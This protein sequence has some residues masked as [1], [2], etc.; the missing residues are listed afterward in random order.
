MAVGALVLLAACGTTVEQARPTASLR[1]VSAGPSEL[2]GEWPAPTTSTTTTTIPIPAADD[3]LSISGSMGPD[4]PLEFTAADAAGAQVPLFQ[5]PNVPVPSGRVLTNPT[6]EGVPLVMLVRKEQG[7]WLQ[8]QVQSRPNGATAWIRRA[9]VVLRKVPNH[10]LVEL[11]AKRLTVFHGQDV[12]W[13]ASVAPGKASSPTPTGSFYVDALAKPNNPNGSYGAYQVSFTGFS[14]VYQTFGK[15]NGQ[16]AA[17]GTNRP[18]LIGTP[19]SHGCVRLS[20]DDVTTLVGLAPQGT[21][22]DVVP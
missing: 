7:D 17:H 10:I 12:V 3:G 1:S 9:D 20:N 13:S 18:E 6:V 22:V 19:A 16:V 4:W 5:A 21:P 15:G 8:V 2:D 14:N 11:G